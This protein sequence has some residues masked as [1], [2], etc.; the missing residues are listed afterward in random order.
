MPFRKI[1]CPVDFSEPSREAL[2]AAARLAAEMSAELT[3]L[4]VWES[5]V[6]LSEAQVTQSDLMEHERK[7]GETALAAWK[8]EAEALGA[9]GVTIKVLVGAPP[10]KMIVDEVASNP[11]YDL[12]VMG[13]HGRTGIVRVLLGSVA[14]RVARHADCPVLLVRNRAMR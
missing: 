8:P 14:E 1:L 6:R 2:K 10:W 5:P 13:T 11:G 7:Q 12:L 3:L 4:Y 9:V